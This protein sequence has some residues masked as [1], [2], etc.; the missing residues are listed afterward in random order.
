MKTE[1]YLKTIDICLS[2][3]KMCRF[4]CPVAEES[5]VETYTPTGKISVL[6]LLMEGEL[7]FN[8]ENV[9]PLYMCLQCDAASDYCPLDVDVAGAIRAG[10]TDAIEKGVILD[11]IKPIRDNVINA[12]S[13]YSD[14][15]KKRQELLQK[16]K[17]DKDSKTLLFLGC[18]VY[19]DQ[20]EIGEVAAFLFHG[21]GM[22]FDVLGDEEPCCGA[23]LL[24]LGFEK[25]AMAYFKEV[26]EVLNKYEKIITI[27]PNCTLMLK[28][29][30]RKYNIEL[31]P[32]IVNYVEIL[33]DS[34]KK[35]AL[36]IKDIP[37][38]V[39]VTFH[40]PCKFKR[41]DLLELPYKILN[42]YGNK[43]KELQRSKK[44]TYCCGGGSS[45]Y[46]LDEELSDKI[47]KNR[48][49]EVKDLNINL[50]LTACPSCK[51]ILSKNA[52]GTGIQVKD[53]L[54]MITR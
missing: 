14:D 34:I 36:K 18:K 22:D 52:H 45:L 25:E 9:Y 47:A 21:L 16:I 28:E 39:T 20:P 43:F 6:Y 15:K 8:K 41:L 2:C 1:D 38:T 27:C 33:Y 11:E 26:S 3:L 19:N 10:R 44:D 24:A 31:K 48:L 35:G 5:G 29:Q 12:K 32:K 50:V 51:R 23:P 49:N 13:I 30:Y 42:K 46:E 40:D 7:E 37:P 53:L 4:V 54:E 17:Y